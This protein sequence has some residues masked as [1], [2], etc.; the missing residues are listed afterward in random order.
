MRINAD[1]MWSAELDP[2]SS[3]DIE[4]NLATIRPHPVSCG[5]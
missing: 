2:Y 3:G 4:V 5:V 1:S